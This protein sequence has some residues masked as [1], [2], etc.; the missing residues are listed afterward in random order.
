LFFADIDVSAIAAATGENPYLADLR[1]DL[2]ATKIR[3][4]LS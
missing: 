3:K 2:Y 1:P 4:G